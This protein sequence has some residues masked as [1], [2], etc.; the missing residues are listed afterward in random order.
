MRLKLLHKWG[1]HI[2]APSFLQKR[3][4]NHMQNVSSPLTI[5][6]VMGSGASDLPSDM[7]QFAC[8]VGGLIARHGYVL[9][10]GGRNGVMYHASRGAKEAGGL[11]IGVLPGLDQADCNPFIDIPIVTGLNDARNL[12]NILSSRLII[13]FAGGGGTLSELGMALKNKVP[14][15]DCGGWK[16]ENS[17]LQPS[18]DLYPA[19]NIQM[20]EQLLTELLV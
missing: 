7:T 2:G 6:G 12:I 19:D 8:D 20:V 11:V 13:A 16:L 5:I 18:L 9:L 15:I 10:T 4:I 1:R 14:V 3:E 17:L